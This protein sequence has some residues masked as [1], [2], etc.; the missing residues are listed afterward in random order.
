M[1]KNKRIPE[2]TTLKEFFKEEKKKWDSLTFLQRVRYLWD[3]YKFP[4]LVLFILLY[5]PGYTLYRR[6]TTKDVRLYVGLVNIAANEETIG[7]LS[8]DYM[9]AAGF[10]RS[11]EDLR[12]Y[13]GWYLT[14][15]RDSAYFEYTYASQLKILASIDAEQLDIVLL[16]RESF[17]AFSQNGYLYNLEDLLQDTPLYEDLKPFLVS[18]IEFVSDNAKDINFDPSVEF[19]S[20]TLE[21][22]MGLDLSDSHVFA[23]AEYSD[24]I[25]LAVIANTPRTDE[26][27]NYLAYLYS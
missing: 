5:I 14:T 18:N 16:D 22:P 12:L 21:Y 7:R 13:T 6:I 20:T 1:F 2:N 19:E 4:F 9:T 3:Y 17:D 27:L 25:Y 15:D 26:V 8:D 23:D 10:N 11:R 24:T